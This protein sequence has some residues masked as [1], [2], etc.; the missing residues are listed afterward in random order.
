MY[1]CIFLCAYKKLEIPTTNNTHLLH[2]SING[3]QWI[4]SPCIYVL[5]NL[6]F[7]S[8]SILQVICVQNN[9]AYNMNEVQPSPL[10]HIVLFWQIF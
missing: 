3:P 6:S 2:C 1:V 8:T 10:F 7:S 9:W 5:C 4:M